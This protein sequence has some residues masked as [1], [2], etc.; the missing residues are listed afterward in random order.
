MAI[1]DVDHSHNTAGSPAEWL[2]NY[3]SDV[4]NKPQD[5]LVE[6]GIAGVAA[7][8]AI[9]PVAR[10]GY[11]ALAERAGTAVPEVAAAGTTVAGETMMSARAV[12]TA[13]ASVR[14]LKYELD[15][16][17]SNFVGKIGPNG[18][19]LLT[20]ESGNAFRLRPLT[21]S[22][23]DAVYAHELVL[24][25]S[26]DKFTARFLTDSKHTH[27]W[28]T[29]DKPVWP[30]GKA[31]IWTN[32]DGAGVNIRPSANTPMKLEFTSD[33]SQLEI[34]SMSGKRLNI[35]LDTALEGKVNSVGQGAVSNRVTS[36]LID[37]PSAVRNGNG[38]IHVQNPEWK[39]ERS[40]SF[41]YPE[42]QPGGTLRIYHDPQATIR[43]A[44]TPDVRFM[45]RTQGLTRQV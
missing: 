7:A 32:L 33:M 41:N 30:N 40:L 14:N 10:L 45:T 38:L 29:L 24:P 26:A 31:G 36:I 11:R 34:A 19:R 44:L 4:W 2:D 17:F 13:V 20:T 23:S 21:G 1:S 12:E 28:S 39:I 3:I 27:S 37:G 18:E 8:A 5:H 42:I 22:S 35:G 43:P 9:S 16:G 15:S 25:Q 6:I